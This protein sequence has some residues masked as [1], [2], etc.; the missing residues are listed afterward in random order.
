MTMVSELNRIHMRLHLKEWEEG[1]DYGP[2]WKEYQNLSTLID[3]LSLAH[4]QDMT[5]YEEEQKGKLK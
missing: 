5:R 1:R 4:S 2:D 3:H